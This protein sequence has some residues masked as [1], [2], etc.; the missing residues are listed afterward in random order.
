MMKGCKSD[1][2][3]KHFLDSVERGKYGWNWSCP[4]NGDKCKYKHCLPPGYRLK[5]EAGQI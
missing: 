2:V 5:G 3:C 4:N 1:I